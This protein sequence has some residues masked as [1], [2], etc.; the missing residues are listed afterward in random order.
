MRLLYLTDRLSDR[1]GADHHLVQVLGFSSAAGHHVVVAFGRDEGGLNLPEG[2]VRRR[3]PGLANRVASTAKLGGLD[4]L[5]ADADVVHLQN[6]MNP[7]VLERLA[8][9]PRVVVTVQDHR[10]FCP[11]PGKTLPDGRVCTEIMGDEVCNGC[12][13]DDEYRRNTL[14]LTHRRLNAVRSMRVVVLSRYMARELATAGVEDV[15]VIPPWVDAGSPRTEA[16]TKILLGGRL[17]AHKGVLG[18]WRA[19]EQAGRPLPLEVA[20]AGP[21]EAELIGAASLG[22]LTHESLREALRRARV[23]LFPAR[24]QEPLGILGLEALAE[25]TP[26]VA[27]ESGGTEDWSDAGCIRVAPSDVEAMAEAVSRLAADPDAALVLGREGQA[28]V[29]E[30]FSE[31][32]I[33]PKLDSL[34]A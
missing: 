13:A 12:L 27:A 26:V 32:R 31:N 33:A 18:A 2:V 8:A 23:L 7:V 16:G 22:W 14:A 4:E 20:G 6:I 10:I 1:G 11:G 28:A 19:W 5:V 17:V 9:H 3:V 24:W 25:G 34:Y 21:L 29:T 15:H 30:R